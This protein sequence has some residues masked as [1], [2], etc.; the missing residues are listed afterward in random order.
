MATIIRLP[1]IGVSEESAV[2]AAWHVHVGDAVKAGDI[3]F[4]LETGKSSFDVEAEVTG[5]VLAIWCEEGE[6]KPIKAPLCVIGAPGEAVP[7]A[8]PAAPAPHSTLLPQSG[9]KKEEFGL[10]AAEAAH[11]GTLLPQSGNKKQES[12]L[13]A[14]GVTHLSEENSAAGAARG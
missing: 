9:N 2:L 8:Q 4:T 11:V 10:W 14:A 1:Q 13:W 12:G 5:T 7:E 3:L 6:E